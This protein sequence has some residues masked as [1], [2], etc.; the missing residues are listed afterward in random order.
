MIFEFE[1]VWPYLKNGGI[2]IS[3]DIISNNAFKDFVN[4]KN[5]VSIVLGDE[6]WSLGIIKKIE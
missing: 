5:G 4:A 3:D 1:T 6:N 2:L